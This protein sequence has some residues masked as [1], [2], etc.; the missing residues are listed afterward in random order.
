VGNRQR[1]SA[2]DP[3]GYRRG[4]GPCRRE[5][6]GDSG[7]AAPYR[8]E[9]IHNRTTDAQGHVN[10]EVNLMAHAVVGAVVAQL[11][12][13]SALAGAA[14]AT[15]GEFIAQQMYPGVKRSDLTEQQRQTISALSTL[16]AGLAGGVAGDSTSGAI[17]GAQGGKNAAENNWLSG[18]EG[19]GVGFQKYVQAQGSLVNNTNLT[20]E[21]GKVLNPAT[22]EQIKYA[23]DKLVTGNFPEGQDP[24]RGLLIAWG[25]GASVLGGELIVPAAGTV[26]VIGGSL[27]GGATDG[28]KQ[29]LTLKPG[30]KYNATDTLI[31]AGEGGL[32][33]GKGLIFSTFINT[34][35]AYLGSKA[36][37][38]DPTVPM[39]GNAIGT[40]LGNKAGDKFTKKMLLKGY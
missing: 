19:F 13:N 18:L 22:P 35:G 36:K 28:I 1:G 4:T 5:Y 10:V 8:A 11:Q 38:E 9:V 37:G 24:A 15:T 27:L 3:G 12:G 25:A 2:G 17:A 20:D 34:M 29:Y 21:K 31:A 33:Q 32:T 16:A 14:G 23:S 26:A 6:A 39:V 30:E 7:G 40:V